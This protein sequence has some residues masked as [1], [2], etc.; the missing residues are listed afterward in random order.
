MEDLNESKQ[1]QLPNAGSASGSSE[2]Q[3]HIHKLIGSINVLMWLVGILLFVVFVAMG[4]LLNNNGKST[5]QSPDTTL[6]LTQEGAS[7]IPAIGDGKD[8]W[9][10]PSEDEMS[11][12]A[13]AEQL[14][15][16]KELIAH[17]A[18]FLGPKGSVAQITNGMNCQN[19]HLKA[20]T[21]PWG[22]NYGSVASTYPKYRARSGGIE[23]VYK[24]VS[25]CFERSLNGKAP[26]KGSK[27]M[28]AIVAYINFIGSNVRKGD[29]A[30][31]S[32][33]YEL[34][35]MDRAADPEK[36]KVL[37]AA[38]CISCH[39]T[40]GSGVLAADGKS[41]TFPPLWGKNS[42]NQG[43]GLYRISRFAGYI[44]ANMPQGATW[45]SPQLT[46][47]EA[48]DIAAYVNQMPRPSKD[49]SKDW[50]K[51]AEKTFDHPFGPYADGFSETQHK[52]GP[53]KPI[54]A[55]KDA[56]TKDKK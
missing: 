5:V 25:D 41:Y 24:R 36:G 17:T 56:L 1:T 38:K 43:A 22:N 30:K 2:Q 47:E 18:N 13:N 7:A 53:F 9:Q 26:L 44:K 55:A 52:F 45:E 28:E 39:Q 37:Y 40:D 6:L 14:L 20:G 4:Y 29:K 3:Q 35:Y 31:A 10:A 42:Y 32:G 34:P 54:K 23:D 8:Y 19:C 50:P 48:W 27:E 46:D 15:Y 16:G 21:Q 11:K 33:I 12:Q 49:L 51:I